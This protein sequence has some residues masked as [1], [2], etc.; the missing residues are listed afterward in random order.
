MTKQIRGKSAE[1]RD[2]WSSPTN[3]FGVIS[4]IL[5]VIALVVSIRSYNASRRATDL[6]GREF[7]ASRLV[8]YKATLDSTNDQLLLSPVD[9]NLQMQYG[10][11]YLPPQLN[12]Q[13]WNISPPQFGF[14]LTM[15]RNSIEDFLEKRVVR[16]KGYI[17]IIDQTSI[18]FVLGSS[19]IAKGQ[20]FT[21]LSL[22]QLMYLAVVSDEPYRRPRITFKGIAFI[23]RLPPSTDSQAYL[24]SVWEDASTSKVFAASGKIQANQSPPQ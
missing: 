13:A 3:I 19:Y 6:A 24:R 9:A 1:G 18:P 4:T 7:V 20:S 21:D 14:P 11:I 15:T 22:Y 17:K 10:V 2:I 12:D 16:E 8:I 23:T 5:S